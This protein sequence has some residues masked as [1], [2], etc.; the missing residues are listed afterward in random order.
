MRKLPLGWALRVVLL[1]AAIFVLSRFTFGQAVQGDRRRADVASSNLEDLASFLCNRAADAGIGDLQILLH[2][3]PRPGPADV[4]AV[5]W[6]VPAEDVFTT[7]SQLRD[8]L[9]AVE[10]AGAP[11]KVS[12]IR[13]SMTCGLWRFDALFSVERRSAAAPSAYEGLMRVLRALGETG[14]DRVLTTGALTAASLMSN[15]PDRSEVEVRMLF[16]A[17]G[18]RVEVLLQL[19]EIGSR[20]AREPGYVRVAMTSPVLL[21]PGRWI[22]E[23]IVGLRLSDAGSFR[24]A[25]S[26]V[27]PPGVGASA[28]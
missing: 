17:E 16:V 4:H 2:Q 7:W 20:L 9:G 14:A 6:L 18:E 5:L 21:D 10:R 3:A 24:R 22:L 1:M 26:R 28:R 27:A 15:G 13:A 8:L 23:L 19:A 11:L 12:A 25:S